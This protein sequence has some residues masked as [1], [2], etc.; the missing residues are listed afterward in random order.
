M[1]VLSIPSHSQGSQRYACGRQT[2]SSPKESRAPR[3]AAASTR[4]RAGRA[5]SGAGGGAPARPGP[6]PAVFRLLA[7]REAKAAG[8]QLGTRSRR[9]SV[10]VGF[11]AR[12]PQ[13]C[14]RPKF[15]VLI[16]RITFRGCRLETQ[17]HTRAIHT[18]SPVSGEGA[19]KRVIKRDPRSLGEDTAPPSSRAPT[20]AMDGPRPDQRVLLAPAGISVCDSFPSCCRHAVDRATRQEMQ[21]GGGSCPAS[22]ASP[23]KGRP[24]DIRWWR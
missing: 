24:P 11:E 4:A 8:A 16:S 23:F 3:Q 9:S 19:P 17:G 21:S 12:G 20:G 6:P 15:A 18:P 1:R 14:Q 13:R 10:P 22:N 7:I 5:S 2:Q